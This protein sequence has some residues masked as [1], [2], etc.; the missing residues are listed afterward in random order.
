VDTG[1]QHIESH[2][3]IVF[4]Y[5]KRPLMARGPA[6]RDDLPRLTSVK[7]SKATQQLQFL[8]Y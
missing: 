8:S 2:Q 5:V 4:L 7:L 1:G 3:Q 6:N